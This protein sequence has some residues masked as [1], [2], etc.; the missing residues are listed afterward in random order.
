MTLHVRKPTPTASLAQIP[1]STVVKLALVHEPL[2]LGVSLNGE[3]IQS[4]K[5]LT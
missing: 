3:C 5:Q 2:L 4:V 1:V